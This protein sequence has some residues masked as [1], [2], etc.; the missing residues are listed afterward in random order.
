[1]KNLKNSQIVT[2][3]L[4]RAKLLQAAQT[5][6]VSR[7]SKLIKRVQ[8]LIKPECLG[9]HPYSITFLLNLSLINLS[10]LPYLKKEVIY[11]PHWVD[12]RVKGV[13]TCEC[14][15]QYLAHVK[16]LYQC[17]LYQQTTK[18]KQNKKIGEAVYRCAH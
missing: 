11:L 2:G 13:N 9:S 6:R 18:T 1:M 3:I 8:T 12:M 14:L 5:R 4:P 17:P 15:D 10:E 7:V 16:V